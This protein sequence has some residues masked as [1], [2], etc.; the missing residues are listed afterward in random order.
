MPPCGVPA[1]YLGSTTQK[2]MERM[3]RKAQFPPRMTEHATGQARVYWHGRTYYLGKFGSAE[4]QKA[5][6]ELLTRLTADGLK[7]DAAPQ[8]SPLPRTVA[9][10]IAAFL[11]FA[12]TEYQPHQVVLFRLALTPL[13][14]LCGRLPAAEFDAETLKRVRST[15]TDGS[16]LN[17]AERE[18]RLKGRM[19]IGWARTTTDRHVKRVMT[20]WRWAEGT[21]VGGAPLVPKGSW[22]NL[23]IL[24]PLKRG[25]PGVRELPRRK[26]TQR[27]D[28]DAVLP[29]VQRRSKRRPVATMLE[30]QYLTGCRSGEVCV[31]RPCDIDRESGPCI[32]GVKVWLYRPEHWKTEHLGQPRV[33]AVGPTAQKL[34]LPWLERCQSPESYLFGPSVSR[35]R[36]PR[37]SVRT[38]AKIVNKACRLAGVKI[39]GYGGR[40]ATADRVRKEHGLD[41]ARSVLGHTGV[42]QTAEY[43]EQLDVQQA[44]EIA[45]KLG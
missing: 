23:T 1:S 29:H 27:A 31:M 25:L 21:K 14:R 8:I 20:V 6:A 15:M 40:R 43:C 28:L 11:A 2:G 33:I 16:W 41:G 7:A 5:Y 36:H 24:R 4:A 12:P 13:L 34:L 22:A 44:A 3:G 42:G 37:Y 39:V 17:D 26:S 32:D 18:Q 9:D 45:A 30:L 35:S 38:Y 10:V 19:P